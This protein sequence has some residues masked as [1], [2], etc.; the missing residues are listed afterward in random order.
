MRQGMTL[1]EVMVALFVLSIIGVLTASTLSNTLQA[2]EILADN[3]DHQQSVRVALDTITRELQLAYLSFN[4]TVP[5][6]YRTIF[7]AT[8]ENPIDNLWF[9][10]LSHHRLY[11]DSREADQTEIT[12][13][14]EDDPNMD[15]AYVLMHREAP[16][17][18]HEPTQDG[19][20]YPLAYGVRRFTVRWLDPTTC[21]WTDEWN[22]TEADYEERLPRAAQ[23]VLGVMGPDPEDDENEELVERSY[24]TTVILQYGRRARCDLGLGQT[25]DEGEI[26]DDDASTSGNSGAATGGS[27]SPSGRSSPFGGMGGGG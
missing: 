15:G 25:D 27:S 9:A 5:N 2:R 20:I 16:R 12:I 22:S 1:V 7:I 19:V 6:S 11:R 23:V 8:D 17:I 4:K 13:W 14:A 21:E 24:A 10:T 3:D 26:S 18:D